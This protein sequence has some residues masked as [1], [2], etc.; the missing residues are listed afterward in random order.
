MEKTKMSFF[1]FCFVVVYLCGGMNGMKKYVELALRKEKKP[2]SLNKIIHRI[3]KI[4]SDER[5]QDVFLSDSEKL[6]VFHILEDGVKQYDVYKTPS[7]N[8][9]SMM[10]TSFRKGRFYGDRTGAGKVSVVTSYLDRD[11]KINVQEA[12]YNVSKDDTNGCI[13]GD[14]VLIDINVNDNTSKVIQILDR[15]LEMIPGEVY[16]VGN[17][18]CSDSRTDY[19]TFLIQ[20]GRTKLA[21]RKMV[22]RGDSSVLWDNY[23]GHNRN[24]WFVSDFSR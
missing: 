8:Y 9:I 12:K 18:Y 3:E 17:S 21:S 16:R 6:D 2:V 1:F 11:G 23:Y 13:D 5:M 4:L 22:S 24:S 14:F 20:N 7:N 10:K 15:Q 19:N